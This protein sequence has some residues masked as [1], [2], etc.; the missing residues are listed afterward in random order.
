[1]SKKHL[2]EER[3]ARNLRQEIG[4]INRREDTS[5]T[6]KKELVQNFVDDKIQKTLD[7]LTKKES[8]VAVKIYKLEGKKPAG[9]DVPWYLDPNR[10]FLNPN[11]ITGEE[12]GSD[13]EAFI[14]FV[15]GEGKEKVIVTD[16]TAGHMDYSYDFVEIEGIL[17][18]RSMVRETDKTG[19]IT[20]NHP[21]GEILELFNNKGNLIK[22][23]S[24]DINNFNGI[25]KTKSSIES[26]KKDNKNVKKI[27]EKFDD[28]TVPFE[29]KYGIKVNDELIK[30]FEEEYWSRFSM[31]DEFSTDEFKKAYKHA[32]EINSSLQFSEMPRNA[33]KVIEL[34]EGSFK[35][36]A[37]VG[38]NKL[39]NNMTI[40]ETDIKLFYPDENPEYKSV[41][42]EYC[43]R[44]NKIPNLQGG[45]N[46]LIFYIKKIE[47]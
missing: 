46:E 35:V 43:Q 41:Y 9:T 36:V 31:K 15:S 17:K 14:A 13:K 25:N 6:E 29:L 26:Q 32:W 37:L 45:N 28:K 4:K 19:N 47:S 39:K 5:K 42:S 22:I 20:P 33:F 34:P 12:I 3:A 16:W 7:K 40:N 11:F 10:K 24:G 8:A 1:M 44:N 2:T 21:E 27:V 18:S 30:S 38:F 23:F